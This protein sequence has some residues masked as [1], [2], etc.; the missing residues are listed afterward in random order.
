MK[1]KFKINCKNCLENK[2][3]SDKI[4]T[5]LEGDSGYSNWTVIDSGK[6]AFKCHGCG[7]YGSSD[8]YD[9][10]NELDNFTIRCLQCDTFDE[11]EYN[12]QDVDGEEEETNMTCKKCGNK[13]E[14]DIDVK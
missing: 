4:Q 11:V 5:T 1:E 7:K 10:P 8:E 9:K 13:L 6:V 14:E 2:M 3:Q 12:I